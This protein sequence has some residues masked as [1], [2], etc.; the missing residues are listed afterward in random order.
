MRKEFIVQSSEFVA[1]KRGGE[2]IMNRLIAAVA[3][4]VLVS[5]IAG[6]L[7]TDTVML[8]ITPAFNLSVNI[9]S[10]TGA[11]GADVTLGSSRTICVGQ[12]TNDGNVSS[13]WQKLSAS[14]TGTDT[15]SGGKVWSLVTSGTPTTDEF[16]LLAITTGTA[17]NPTIHGGGAMTSNCMDGDHTATGMGMTNG[18]TDLTEGGVSSPN[19]AM[20]ETKS[21]WVSVMMP[22]NVTGGLEQ[23]ITL[24]VKAIAP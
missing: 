2:R 20:K 15:T 17:I 9:S 19:H 23:T 18:P 13:K 6:A 3:L 7:T 10:A 24:S 21:L 8:T 11:F 1:I 14:Q 4:V 22:V 12:V 16:R 5:G